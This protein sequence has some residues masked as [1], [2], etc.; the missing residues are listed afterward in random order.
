MLSLRNLTFIMPIKNEVLN[1]SIFIS[2]VKLMYKDF[3][4]IFVY[5]DDDETALAEL[6]PLLND[7][8]R[9]IKN[10]GNGVGD[11]IVSGIV[12]CKTKYVGVIC[13][14]DI[15]PI[16]FL[17]IIANELTANP[18]AI[19]GMTRYAKGGARLH[20]DIVQIAFSKTANRILSIFTGVSDLTCAAR[21]GDREMMLNLFADHQTNGW[22]VNLVFILR[23]LKRKI[24]L[25][26]IPVVSVDEL[27][28][29]KSSFDLKKW[30]KL[31]SQTL[32]KHF[33]FKRNLGRVI[34]YRDES[35]E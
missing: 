30:F 31:Y 11:A 34:Y 8:V 15:G 4:L 28:H 1:P 26:E 12:A 3:E 17:D 6:R 24:P 7:S 13:C 9:A 35:N 18:K 22:E 33:T 25:N 29:G 5:D 10:S 21:Y 27:R 32:M 16:Y 2:F 14:D 20:G 19:I 23:A